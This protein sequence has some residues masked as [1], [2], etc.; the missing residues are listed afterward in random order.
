MRRLWKRHAWCQKSLLLYCSWAA[1]VSRSLSF[2]L[3]SEISHRVYID[4]KNRAMFYCARQHWIYT[5]IIR[6]WRQAVG[7]HNWIYQTEWPFCLS[8]KWLALSR[9]NGT[10]LWLKLRSLK[11]WISTWKVIIC[12]KERH[13]Y[14]NVKSVDPSLTGNSRCE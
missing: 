14:A 1:A 3:G 4:V 10:I 11:L 12:H 6:L 5:Y 2:T 8:S 13:I 7:C 9:R